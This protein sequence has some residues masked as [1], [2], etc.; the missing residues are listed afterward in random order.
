MKN[1]PNHS[2]IGLFRQYYVSYTKLY[3]VP[4]N[5]FFHYESVGID[6]FHDID[7]EDEGDHY[8]IRNMSYIN[9]YGI[10]RFSKLDVWD[11]SFLKRNNL[12]D[13]RSILDKVI[14]FYLR[15]TSKY[16]YLFVFRCLDRI[17]KYLY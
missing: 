14:H 4:L 15:K 10:K 5:T 17:M 9:K 3:N 2:A 16:S 11:D 1:E 7:F 6:L 12:K 13:P 8:T